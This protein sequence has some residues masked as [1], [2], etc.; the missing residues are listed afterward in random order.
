[1]ADS[2]KLI[3]VS[4]DP[5]DPMNASTVFEL[6]VPQILCN[7]SGNLHGGAVALVFDICTSMTVVAASKEDFWDAGH[8]SRALNC[9]YIRPAP[10]GTVLLVEN[11]IVHLG[12][13]LGQLKGT[14]RRKDNGKICYTCVHDKVQVTGKEKL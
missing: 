6:T 8:V 10:L 13:S 11:E 2:L 14:M 7:A 9:Q 5:K 3:S 4:V 1:V 12:R